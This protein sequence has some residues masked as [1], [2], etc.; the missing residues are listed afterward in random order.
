MPCCV[1]PQFETHVCCFEFV[2]SPA[3]RARFITGSAAQLLAKPGGGAAWLLGLRSVP[4]PEASAAL[5]TLMGV[6]PKVATCCIRN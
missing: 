3:R 1:D 6:G 4:Y 2:S 5:C